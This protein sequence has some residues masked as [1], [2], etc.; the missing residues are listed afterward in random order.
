MFFYSNIY[1]DLHTH[2]FCCSLFLD[3]FFN[4]DHFPFAWRILFSVFDAGLPLENLL[5][6]IYLLFINYLFTYLLN[7]WK[8]VGRCF[9]SCTL[10]M[11][12]CYL[13]ALSFPWEVSCQSY[14]CYVECNVLYLWLLLVFS[15]AFIFKNLVLCI[16]LCSGCS[17]LF[18]YINS[19]H[20][21]VWEILACYLF[22]YAVWLLLYS[23]LFVCPVTSVI[24]F[25]CLPHVFCIPF[26]IYHSVLSFIVNVSC[27]PIF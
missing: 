13:M 18:E 4:L 19:W 11:S 3:S 15:L 16:I 2:L 1:I 17:E 26:C 20:K 23:L 22:I 8:T 27:E 14:P 25:D 7:L 12:F 24:P 6:S 5:I 9:S 10:K 21:L